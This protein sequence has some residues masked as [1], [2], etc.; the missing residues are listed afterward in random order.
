MFR[1]MKIGDRVYEIL[2]VHG[3]EHEGWTYC[4]GL[5]NRGRAMRA[6]MGREDGE[7]IDRRQREIPADLQGKITF[8]FPVWE[9]ERHIV[10]G[11]RWN[12]CQW[13]KI[14]GRLDSLAGPEC[15]FVRR[16]LA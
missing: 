7:F 12:G 6:D 5:K 15:R 14:V 13:E 10:V 4:W 1:Q 16:I 8:V 3:P 2:R 11:I 9:E